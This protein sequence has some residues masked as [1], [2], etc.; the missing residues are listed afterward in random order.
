MINRK[1]I[2]QTDHIKYL[3]VTIDSQLTFTQHIINVVKK[4][5]RVT[6]L[7]YRIRGCVDNS[8]LNM[9]Y[10]SLIYPHLL[11]G[12]PIWGNADNIHINPL[13]I[14]QKKAVRL[15]L[16]KHRNI[17]TIYELPRSTVRLILHN[18]NLLID[19]PNDPVMYWYVDTFTKVPSD[20][21]FKKLGILKVHD[22][23]NLTTLKFV[24]ESLN[25]LNPNQFHTYYNYPIGL[26][27]T[28][29]NRDRNLDPP[30]ARTVTYGLKS[31]KYS[32]CILWNDLPNDKRSAKSKSVFSI[33][34]KK[35][36]INSYNGNE[37]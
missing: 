3:G 28:A 4:V 35:H 34:I 14:L 20:P 16:N 19:L 15:I 33:L 36:I 5:S 13:L 21:L 25:K 32:G 22:I 31:L 2:K 9:I 27:N 29:A 17:Q 12:I 18:D 7:M 8:T 1:A 10:Y 30:M 37:E 26:H 23:Y 6:G 24:Y 11:Y